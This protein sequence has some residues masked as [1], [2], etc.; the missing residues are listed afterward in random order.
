MPICIIEGPSGLTPTTK[1]ELISHLLQAMV[2]AYQMPD[3]RVFIH[4][5]SVVNTGHTGMRD[6]LP[7]SI[8]LEP[9]RPVCTFL[10]PPGLPMEERRTLIRITTGHIAKAYG[11]TDWQDVLVFIQEY[12]LVNVGNNGLLQAENPAFES[13]AT[14]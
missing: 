4:E 6:G 12:P 11:I 14:V 7:D 2:D 1:K 8:Q 5:H 3:D 10:A 13:P 9:A